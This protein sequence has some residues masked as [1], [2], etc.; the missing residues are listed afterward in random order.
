MF[1]S[2]TNETMNHDV[3]FNQKNKHFFSSHKINKNNISKYH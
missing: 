1:S 3:D 2:L